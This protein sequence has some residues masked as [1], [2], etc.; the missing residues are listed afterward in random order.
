MTK[1]WLIAVMKTRAEIQY[2]VIPSSL[3]IFWLLG[4]LWSVKCRNTDEY[5]HPLLV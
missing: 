1:I 2:C 4:Y 5:T 3:Y